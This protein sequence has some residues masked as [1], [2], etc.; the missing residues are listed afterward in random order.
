MSDLIEVTF[1]PADKTAWVQ[2][3]ANLVDAG[4]AAGLEIV[5]GCTRGVC[6]TDP[7][8]IRSGAEGL[9]PPSDDERATLERMGI[10][11]AYR[12]ACSAKLAAGPVVVELGAF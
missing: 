12:L 4:A 3:G 8:L 1:L 10:G 2:S 6:G 11:E 5:T 9:V 7:V